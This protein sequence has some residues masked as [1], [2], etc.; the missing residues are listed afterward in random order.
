MN[1]IAARNVPL[2]HVSWKGDG[3]SVSLDLDGELISKAAVQSDNANAD[4]AFLATLNACLKGMTLRQARDHGV[5]H[6][7]LKFYADGKAVPVKGIVMPRNYS[8]TSR[9]AAQA[10]RSAIDA[11]QKPDLEN[12][13]FDDNGLSDAWRKLPLETRMARLDGLVAEY[14]KKAGHPD[15]A[16]ITEIDEYERVFLLFKPE[17]PIDAKPPLLMQL[18]RY[19]RNATAER[20]E[21]FVSELKDNNRTRRL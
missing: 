12:W 21:L 4:A 11:V 15:A 14:L 16:E 7:C 13:N 10:L 8:A 18:E 1:A 3:W 9:D 19:I 17:F 2:N 20:I 6:A 5:Q